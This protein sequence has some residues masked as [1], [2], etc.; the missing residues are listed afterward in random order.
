MTSRDESGDTP[1]Q[2]SEPGGPELDGF[3]PARD[4]IADAFDR[5]AEG[6]DVARG[7]SA[8]STAVR[9]RGAD[10]IPEI[11]TGLAD[12]SGA[13]RMAGARAL[14]GLTDEHSDAVADAVPEL[15]AAVGD[16]DE[17]VRNYALLALATLAD[18][19]PEAVR[20]AV[21]AVG[22]CLPADS[23]HVRTRAVRVL[24]AVAADA[25]GDVA[26]FLPELVGVATDD[27][28]DADGGP[29]P[30]ALA[31][32]TEPSGPSGTPGG[33]TDDGVPQEFATRAHRARDAKTEER[34][35]HGL[36]RDEAA[37]AVA[38]AS[39]ADPTALEAHLTELFDAVA[40]DPLVEPRAALLAALAA[41]A[42]RDPAAVAAGAD[43]IAVALGERE[44]PELQR[45]AARTLALSADADAAAVADAVEPYLDD[46]R[47]MLRTDDPA[48]R[49]AAVG[50]LA[51]VAEHRPRAVANAAGEA[52]LDCASDDSEPVRAGAVWCLLFLRGEVAGAQDALREIAREDPSEEIRQVAAQAGGSGSGP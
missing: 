5:V 9:E 49:A 52:V 31:G 25:P 41:V 43:R 24:G 51:Y 33:G 26:P 4:P 2:E 11:S 8:L 22:S 28:G 39:A 50:L 13:P 40:S 44:Y 7:A 23:Q 10:A 14:A 27:Q 37:Q 35:R 38:D 19:R 48:V 3:D 20:P 32:K 12:R 30:A 36:V 34:T 47:E 45:R 6:L 15:T 42:E 16:G 17:I 18:E 46:L 21:E 29:S 1:P